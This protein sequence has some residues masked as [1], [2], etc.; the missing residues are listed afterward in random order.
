MELLFILKKVQCHSHYFL[1]RAKFCREKLE[2][3]SILGP[4]PK[5]LLHTCHSLSSE[6]ELKV[7]EP[8]L[9][10]IRCNVDHALYSITEVLMVKQ[11]NLSRCS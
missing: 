1:A 7:L 9:Y 11:I 4:V 6:Q 5:F 10:T 2:P 8:I 3:R